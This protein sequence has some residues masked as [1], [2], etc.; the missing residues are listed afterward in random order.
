MLYTILK[1]LILPPGGLILLLLL[2]FF[3]V[4]GVLG[5]LILF[6]ALVTLTLISLPMVTAKMMEG[7]E[8]YPP[9]APGQP[10]PADVQAILVLGAGRYRWGEMVACL[11]WLRRFA[12]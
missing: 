4:R 6:V 2:A 9:I 7:L 10:V 3:L 8:T 11:S 5:R 1:A 12:G